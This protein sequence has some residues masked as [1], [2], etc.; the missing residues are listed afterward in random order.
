MTRVYQLPEETVNI[1][2]DEASIENGRHIF[3]F[4]GCEACHSSG[5]YLDLSRPG[6]PLTTHL[7]SPS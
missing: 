5:E 6:S 3:R 2:S 1:P 7:S 4:R